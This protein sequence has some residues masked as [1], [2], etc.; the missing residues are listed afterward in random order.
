MIVDQSRTIGKST[1]NPGVVTAF[2]A[3]S[4][5]GWL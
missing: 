3:V 2:V 4:K 5:G 1:P